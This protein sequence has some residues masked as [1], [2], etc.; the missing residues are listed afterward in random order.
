ME[1]LEIIFHNINDRLS[2]NQFGQY[3]V[4]WCRICEAK[5]NIFEIKKEF[6]LPNC[7]T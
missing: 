6:G 1:N 3:D 4:C 5:L 7:R 2:F